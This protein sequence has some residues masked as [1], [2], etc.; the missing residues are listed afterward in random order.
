MDIGCGDGALTVRL[1]KHLLE[2]GK[3][4]GF[5]EILLIDPSSAM[6]SMAREKVS[7]AFPDVLITT[8]NA[9]IQDFSE[10]IDRHFDIAMSSLAY[11]HMP[12]EDK[13]V[14]LS[15]LKPWI[16]NFLLFEMDANNDTPDLDSPE[17][18]LSVY[19]SYGRILDFVFSYD[20]PVEIV[21]DCIDSFLMTEL[22]SLLT[23]PRG[24]RTEYH[25]LRSQWMNLF[26]YVLGDEFTL[27][28]DSTCYADEYCG[29]FTL[30]YGREIIY[31]SYFHLIIC[32]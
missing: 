27:R 7:A 1:L 14:H 12:I 15:R 18:A 25:M 5:S 13:K 11:H 26:K 29:L 9:R 17:L 31:S 24:M 4:P 23:E 20:A 8:D 32:L 22:V 30:H 2:E 19:Q 28:S 3:V 16:D 6:I 10:S 21:I